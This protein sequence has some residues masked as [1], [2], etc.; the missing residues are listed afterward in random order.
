MH[1]V[2]DT[3]G[4][5]EAEIEITDA[6]KYG[7]TIKSSLVFK[8]AAPNPGNVFFVATWVKY[9][10]LL[11]KSTGQKFEEYY[12]VSKANIIKHGRELIEESVIMQVVER[13][14]TFKSEIEHPKSEIIT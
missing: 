13:H 11:G 6:E 8:G 5:E 2:R 9:N 3:S 4:F 1:I 7:I 12:Q 14:F 10:R